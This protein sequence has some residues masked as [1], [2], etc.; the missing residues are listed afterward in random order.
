MHL[1]TYGSLLGEG[2]VR[3]EL[4]DML[5]FASRDDGH[6]WAWSARDLGGDREP[7]VHS[8]PRALDIAD[9]RVVA[10]NVSELL[11]AWRDEL[12]VPYFV[13]HGPTLLVGDVPANGPAHDRLE[14]PGGI[15][16]HGAGGTSKIF[17]DEAALLVS[18]Q[19]SPPGHTRAPWT[20]RLG[21]RGGCAQRA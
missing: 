19:T 1:Q 14:L 6:H 5:V 11:A 12:D 2:Y 21:F 20:S 10:S 15:R 16:L 7:P 17:V 13:P 9:T 4:A 8:I 18:I 3:G